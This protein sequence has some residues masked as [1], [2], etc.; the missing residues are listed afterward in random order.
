M[1][2]LDVRVARA[3]EAVVA[4]VVG[5]DGLR[6]ARIE[7][8]GSLYEDKIGDLD[9]EFL[10]L[11]ANQ[12][13]L[14]ILNAELMV[15]TK[16]IQEELETRKKVERAKEILMVRR[17]MTGDEAH[18]WIQK[19]S[20]DSRKH[21]R[22]V[23]EAIDTGREGGR[24]GQIQVTAAGD[25]DGCAAGLVAGAV[26]VGGASRGGLGEG[27][28]EGLADGVA[29]Q[30]S[31]VL[32]RDAW[33]QIRKREDLDVHGAIV[34]P[35]SGS[36]V[37][38]SASASDDGSVTQVKFLVDGSSIGTV[39]SAPYEVTWDGRDDEGRPVPCGLYW[40]VLEILPDEPGAE[41]EITE[42]S[43]MLYDIDAETSTSAMTLALV[44]ASYC[45]T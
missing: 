30:L 8:I 7:Q 35:V 6:L 34:L 1:R 11:F 2:R 13:A 42:R 38:I 16:V 29:A 3:G 40:A 22:Q 4:L 26:R 41:P 36:S 32:G 5:E 33:A 19:K 21:V 15:K 24:Q 31:D 14:A 44:S 37:K 18:R 43:I 23:A 39:S 25:V 27:F 17:K 28:F 45:F 10:Q 12:A 9:Q 20:M